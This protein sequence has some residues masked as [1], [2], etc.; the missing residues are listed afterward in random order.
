MTHFA[1]RELTASFFYNEEKKYIT[2]GT[3]YFE[4]GLV[5]TLEHSKVHEDADHL[6]LKLKNTGS[7]NTYQIKAAK[8]LDLS[9][10]SSEPLVYHG[11]TGD[12][13]GETS[14]LPVDMVISERYHEEP[15]GGRSSDGTGFPYFD[16][17]LGDE[18]AVIAIGWTGQW[19]KDICATDTGYNLQIGL[20][21]SYFYL[22]PGEEIRLASVLLVRGKG[23]T[24]TRNQFRRILREFYSPKAYLG[25]NMF[26]PV[27]IQCFDRYYAGNCGTNK[28][29]SWN[30]EE[31]QRRTVDSAKKID[32]IDTLWLDAAW[33]T[34]Y[35][36]SGVGNYSFAEGFPNTLKPVS[37]YAHANGMKF[38]L[39]FEPERVVEGTETFSE[40][41]KLLTYPIHASKVKRL[42]NLADDNARAWLKDKL[43]TMI[44]ENGVDVYRQDFN[45]SPL[46]FWCH[47]DEECRSGITE[48]KYISGM[49]E[50]WDD[51]L[52][53][54]P[55]ILIDNC[56]SGGRRLD[57]ETAKRSVTLWK[58]DT[59][60]FPDTDK[61]HGTLWSQNQTLSISRYLPYQACAV[62]EID[63]YTVRS[64]A[65][66]GL[67]C[68]FDIF[69]PDFDFAAAGKILSEVTEMKNYWDGDFYPLSEAS[70]D[71]TIWAMFQLACGDRG[72][73]YAFR[74]EQ[75][76]QETCSIAFEAID[77]DK[78]Y[79]LTFV[80]EYLNRTDMEYSGAKLLAGIPVTI[81][82]K[83]NSLII[84]YQII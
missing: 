43:I 9:V 48:I 30:T 11:L 2:P 39:W 8:T 4:K 23:I 57:L 3:Y 65:T 19:S 10:E 42:F 34:K 55:G 72:A 45:M 82:D 5:A 6:L 63:A 70:N 81:P 38:V 1:W 41:D 68:N 54:F 26:L 37:D 66:Q 32:G 79:S 49:Y 75:C 20:R 47:N 7:E 13:C 69:N 44:R 56:S 46:A 22:K 27:S 59:G 60:C 61:M 58:S 77:A 83:R 80:D 35:F 67:A 21:Y 18:T 62:W 78:T 29:L 73:L 17:T 15:C 84:K 64:T 36:P 40:T 24:A 25:E 51:I 74:R 50:L 28:D 12:D 14:F 52:E 76:E 16:L 33:F 53:Q 71:E 31:G